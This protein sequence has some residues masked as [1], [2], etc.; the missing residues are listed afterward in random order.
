MKLLLTPL[1][2][3]CTLAQAQTSTSEW[4]LQDST[5]KDIGTY[6]TQSAC[7]AAARAMTPNN[8]AKVYGCPRMLKVQGKVVAPPPPPPPPPAPPPAPAPASNLPFVDVSKIPAA[9]MGATG[10]RITTDPAIIGGLPRPN[11]SDSGAFR[12]S[13]GYSHMSFD[14]PILYQGQPGKSHLHTFFCNDSTDANSTTDSLLTKGG[15]T[16][17][18]G[19]LNRSAYWTPSVID[20]TDGTPVIPTGMLW[21]GKQGYGGVKAA[22]IQPIPV[23]LRLVAGSA[24]GNP[25]N[26][27]GAGRF[28]CVGGN[29]GVGWQA[30][31]PTNCFADNVMIMEV[32]FAQC[33]SGQE[34]DSPDHKSHMAEATGNGCPA[35]HPVALPKMSF[36]VYLPMP[37]DLSRLKKW[38]LSSDNYDPSLPA[39]YSIHGDLIELWDVTTQQKWIKNCLNASFDCHTSFVS[40][41]EFLY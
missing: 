26:P 4:H 23:G 25:T 2:L 17:N 22:D 11:P 24:A 15:S 38:R 7:D 1:F 28:A 16:C 29:Q 27:S 30:T 8:T 5:G 14:D 18:G 6:S 21:Y 40:P 41:T 19:T 35:T 32:D 37:K 39:G 34:L 10:P 3:A 33:W 20:T 9:V 12:I 36:E 13:A 31:I